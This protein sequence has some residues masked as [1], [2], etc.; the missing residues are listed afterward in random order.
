MWPGN[1]LWKEPATW[2]AFPS[3]VTFKKSPPLCWS[4]DSAITV[5]CCNQAWTPVA[6]HFHL[7]AIRRR[8]PR[9]CGRS[10]CP[11][12]SACGFPAKVTLITKTQ[13]NRLSTQ[14]P[15]RVPRL[16][17]FLPED[18]FLLSSSVSHLF[19]WAESVIWVNGQSAWPFNL[20][21]NKAKDGL[22][23]NR[24][25]EKQTRRQFYASSCFCLVLCFWG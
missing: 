8:Q 18:C 17:D 16:S 15:S 19:P 25:R 13:R 14:C 6:D 21:H 12:K 7:C 9:V 2:S 11:C 23:R 10:N 4:I 3:K 22:L 5:Q 20:L 1:H 24:P